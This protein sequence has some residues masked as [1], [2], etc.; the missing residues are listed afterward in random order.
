MICAA[1]SLTGFAHLRQQARSQFADTLPFILTTCFDV[2]D[3]KAMPTFR[4]FIFDAMNFHLD[5]ERCKCSSDF[6][7]SIPQQLIYEIRMR[8]AVLNAAISI[9]PPSNSF[10]EATIRLSNEH[11]LEIFRALSQTPRSQQR[12]KK[13]RRKRFH[14]R[15]LA[16]GVRHSRNLVRFYGNLA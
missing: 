11:A 7:D 2:H 10:S 12:K 14:R 5:L 1:A 13:P 4:V 15:G 9:K 6:R 3:T 16:R 8:Y